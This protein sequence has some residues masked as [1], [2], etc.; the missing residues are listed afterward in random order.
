MLLYYVI[1]GVKQSVL[2]DNGVKLF[3]IFG[4]AMGRSCKTQ[5]GGF[6]HVHI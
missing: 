5:L 2:I 3:K 1:F 4:V 6:I